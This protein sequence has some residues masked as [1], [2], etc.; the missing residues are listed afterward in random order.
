MTGK[1]SIDKNKKGPSVASCNEGPVER[2]GEIALSNQCHA[3][4][5]GPEGPRAVGMAR[6]CQNQSSAIRT[7]N[8]KHLPAA[9]VRESKR[10]RRRNLP[11][12][13]EKSERPLQNASVK[14]ATHKALRKS[15]VLLSLGS[16]DVRNHTARARIPNVNEKS[17]RQSQQNQQGRA[18]LHGDIPPQQNWNSKLSMLKFSIKTSICQALK[19]S[20]KYW[21][22]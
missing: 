21:L 9:I 12:R 15:P 8:E 1:F 13:S 5:V 10:S 16:G 3:L 4:V 19:N 17:N 2:R 11:A 20:Q 22:L 14:Q 18:H 7:R 6:S